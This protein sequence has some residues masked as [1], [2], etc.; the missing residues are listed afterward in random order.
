VFPSLFLHNIPSIPIISTQHAS[1]LTPYHESGASMA[2]RSSPIQFEDISLDRCT[3]MLGIMVL[4]VA[5]GLLGSIAVAFYTHHESD[6]MLQ[7]GATGFFAAMDL[8]ALL[9]I[10]RLAVA[11]PLPIPTSRDL[12]PRLRWMLALLIPVDMLA[13]GFGCGGCTL[14][15]LSLLAGTW[16]M[17]GLAALEVKRGRGAPLLLTLSLLYATP[18]CMCANVINRWWIEQMGASP[19]CYAFALVGIGFAVLGLRGV[20]PRLALVLAAAPGGAALAFGIGHHIF[21]YPW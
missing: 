16:I 12:S 21:A 3:A 10:A 5:L 14:I 4:A 9:F 6:R 8:S 19:N 18:H 7:V 2:R 20:W 1:S 17:A 15:C 13:M 11:F